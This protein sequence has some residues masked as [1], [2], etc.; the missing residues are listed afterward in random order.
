M[1]RFNLNQNDRPEVIS[2][3]VKA[4]ELKSA[5]SRDEIGTKNAL[6]DVQ[7][8]WSISAWTPCSQ[9]CGSTGGGYRVCSRFI[10][11]FIYLI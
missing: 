3:H 5:Q 10:L 8:E 9:T 6:K 7:F 1:N 11:K 4:L 2:K